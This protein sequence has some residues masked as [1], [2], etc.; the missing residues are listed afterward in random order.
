MERVHG[1]GGIFFKA[2]DPKALGAWYAKHLGIRLTEWGGAI[3]P[4]KPLPR[5]ARYALTVWSPFAA[6]TDHFG[7][8]PQQHMVNYQVANLA[9]MLAQ[10]RAAGVAVDEKTQTSEQGS[11]GWAADP[12]GNRF[13]L[14]E[15]AHDPRPARR[16]PKPK[17]RAAKRKR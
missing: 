11:F 8:G 7:A 16:R 3:L 9:K 15:P 4:W 12:E 10:L 5:A 6:D 17:A 13:E 14:W 1:I 2:R